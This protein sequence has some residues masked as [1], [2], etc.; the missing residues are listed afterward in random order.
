ML[1]AEHHDDESPKPLRTAGPERASLGHVVVS[2]A[3]VMKPHRQSHATCLQLWATCLDH[4]LE[5][6]VERSDV[7]L[8]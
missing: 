3:S 2:Q 8:D 6:D 4:E 5:A 7:T 1:L